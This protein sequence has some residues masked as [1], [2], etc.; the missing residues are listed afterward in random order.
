MYHQADTRLP[1][2]FIGPGIYLQHQVQS[3]PDEQ[4]YFCT[5][6]IP[7][8]ILKVQSTNS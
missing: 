6:S 8:G 5:A 2:V 4:R 3:F 7:T 1:G